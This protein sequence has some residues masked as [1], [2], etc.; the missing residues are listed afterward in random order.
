MDLINFSY[1]EC[2]HW[3][4]SGYVALFNIVSIIIIG[5][6]L[7]GVALFWSYLEICVTSIILCLCPVLVIMVLHFLLWVVQEEILP[8]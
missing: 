2:S 6:F 5:F 3:T 7:V 8:P 1:G 4:N